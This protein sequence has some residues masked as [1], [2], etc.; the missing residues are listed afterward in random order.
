MFDSKR[1]P[2]STQ[3]V[4]RK[5]E[6]IEP[7]NQVKRKD[8]GVK[9]CGSQHG[10]HR[11]GEVMNAFLGVGDHGM[12]DIETARQAGRPCPL[13]SEEQLNAVR[14]ERPRVCPTTAQR[15][16]GKRAAGSR[17]VS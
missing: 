12:R 7:R 13:L 8:D 10:H 15:E 1:R 16:E 5:V 4:S 17:I 2:A 3:A 9:M 14:G 6:G 11:K